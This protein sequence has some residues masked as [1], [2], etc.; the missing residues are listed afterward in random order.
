MFGDRRVAT[1]IFIALL[2]LT[3]VLT[4]TTISYTA[5][6]HHKVNNLTEKVNLIEKISAQSYTN[7]T[8]RELYLLPDIDRQT[9]RKFIKDFDSF[10]A[11]VKEHKAKGNAPQSKGK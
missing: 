10:M 1:L 7:S 9:L 11:A 8:P 2:T 3:L 5:Q 4:I 6:H